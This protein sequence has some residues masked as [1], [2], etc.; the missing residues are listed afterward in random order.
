MGDEQHGAGE[1]GEATSSCSIAGRS[2]W[3]VGSSSTSRLTPLAISTPATPASARRATTSA[4]HAGRGRRPARTWR[5]TSGHRP[6]RGRSRPGTHAASSDF[7]RR[8]TQRRGADRGPERSHR[9]RRQDHAARCRRRAVDRPSTASSSV[10]LP[11]PLAPTIATR[12]PEPISRSI[13]P[14]RKSARARSTAP[15]RRATT[16]PLRPAE[17]MSRRS[18][19]GTR[20]LSTTSS[21][22]IARSVRAAWPASCSVWLTRKDGCACRFRPSGAPWPGPGGPLALALRLRRQRERLEPYSSNRSHAWRSAA[23]AR[24]GTRANRR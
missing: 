24:R 18:S 5:A 13:G 17:A 12:S 3:L 11:E 10:V 21:R 9:A 6:G 8:P 19:H 2:R 15:S 22:P 7:G 23:A 16:S 4:G 1:R 14:R 20:G